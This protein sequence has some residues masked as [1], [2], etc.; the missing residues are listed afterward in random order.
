VVLGEMRRLGGAGM[1]GAGT[2]WGEARD[3]CW[4][5]V[6]Q[7]S[8]GVR[9]VSVNTRG[10]GDPWQGKGVGGGG[11]RALLV[12]IDELGNV[13]NTARSREVPAAITAV[14]RCD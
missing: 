4:P 12:A 5:P 9:C 11:Q 3:D 13:P 2:V 1:A 6:G 14:T 10:G 8:C 7:Y